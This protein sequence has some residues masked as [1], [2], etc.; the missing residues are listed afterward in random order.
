MGEWLNKMELQGK[1]S[2]KGRDRSVNVNVHFDDCHGLAPQIRVQHLAWYS[3][4][5]E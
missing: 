4:S 3:L 1:N 5:K 2:W